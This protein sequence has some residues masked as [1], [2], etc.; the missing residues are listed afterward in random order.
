M[1]DSKYRYILYLIVLVIIATIGI[2]AY[3]NYKNY[4][5]NKQ[6]LINDVQVSLDG[7][8]DDYYANLA[9]RSTIGF[10]IEDMTQKEFLSNG[11]FDSILDGIEMSE[12]DGFSGLESIDPKL[13]EGIAIVKGIN[14]DSILS[15]L[16]IKGSVLNNKKFSPASQF[17]ENAQKDL[18]TS[19]NVRLLTSKVII[20]MT[21]DSLSLVGIDTLLQAE[22][23]RKDIVI[24]YLIAYKDPSADM[25]YYDAIDKNLETIDSLKYSSYLQ[26]SSKSTF[27]PKQSELSILFSNIT[28][29]IFKRI[30]I[31][32]II[33][34]VLVLTVISCLFYLLHI[35]NQQKQ[36]AE[37]KN[38]L[39][40]N[41][42]HEFKTPISTIGVALESLGHFDGLSD[43]VRT[44]RYLQLSKAQLSKLNVMV[45]KLLETATLD[46]EAIELQL[47]S[48][49]L[50][51]LL[52]QLVEKH[53]FQHKDKSIV[54]KP[55]EVE[56][57]IHVDAFHFENAI[58]NILDN[59]LKYGGSEI[60]ISS[61]VLRDSVE[62]LISD[63][64]SSLTKG[65]KEQVFDKF[66]R[67]PKGN[68]HDVKGFGIGLY[69]TKKIIEK[70]HG[71]IELILKPNHTT[72]KISL[73][74]G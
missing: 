7:A 20:S 54:L 60:D 49:N 55:S 10:G 23:L 42:T 38:D 67:V 66:Y 28:E 22:L 73:P 34:T 29:T 70:H 36:L 64:G 39:I 4:L 11:K 35:I 52:K 47:E 59:A 12:T 8:V 61:E 26:T 72:F 17:P 30:A 16:Q 9:E 57:T 13:I 71:E 43:K 2:Q 24:N 65:Q 37:V 46:S 1:N 58:N 33:S 27:L 68:Q 18:L 15:R 3:W 21:T 6:Q 48:V 25:D 19:K 40:N 56:I 53:G 62:I 14:A 41:I 45:E 69:Y 32:L 50:N 5:A 31:G 74:N 63:S 44:Q 51:A